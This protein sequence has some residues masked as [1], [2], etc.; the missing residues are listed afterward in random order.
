[1]NRPRSW[2]IGSAVGGIAGAPVLRS[3]STLSTTSWRQPRVGWLSATACGS[4]RPLGEKRA[5]RSARSPASQKL[6]PPLTPPRYTDRIDREEASHRPDAT[7]SS[8][9]ARL[10]IVPPPHEAF[11]RSG[12]RIGS[13]TDIR[14]RPIAPSI[15]RRPEPSPTPAV[16]H[17][18][19]RSGAPSVRRSTGTP[20]AH[21]VTGPPAD[22]H[23][24][25]MLLWVVK[26]HFENIG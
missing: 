3:R 18:R 8:T 2:N 1:M 14:K 6:G 23:A 19:P 20:G 7:A 15:L 9:K 12:G 13:G 25:M 22:T 24:E 5:S 16:C 21:N 26:Q 4:A 10:R 17:G 11:F